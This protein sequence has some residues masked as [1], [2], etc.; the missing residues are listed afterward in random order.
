M[1]AVTLDDKNMRKTTQL[2]LAKKLLGGNDDGRGLIITA[3]YKAKPDQAVPIILQGFL[4]DMM[5]TI[6]KGLHD[7]RSR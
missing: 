5:S 3:P 4:D 7:A 1:L 2:T 6:I